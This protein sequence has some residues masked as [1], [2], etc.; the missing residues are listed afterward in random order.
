MPPQQ[1]IHALTVLDYIRRE[2]ERN[3]VLFKTLQNLA[4]NG[5]RLKDNSE[6]VKQYNE[7]LKSKQDA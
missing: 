1:K 7:F 3:K 4:G 6:M 5:V 2:K